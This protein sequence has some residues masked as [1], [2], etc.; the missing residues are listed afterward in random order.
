[1]KDGPDHVP[2]FK[3]TAVVNGQSFETQAECKSAKDAQ[4]SVAKM[5]YDYFSISTPPRVHVQQSPSA[6]SPVI[7]PLVPVLEMQAVSQLPQIPVSPSPS[8]LPFPP[9]GNC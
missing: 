5:A 1:M 8:S 6:D 3:A 7:P 4:N 9:P 2:R